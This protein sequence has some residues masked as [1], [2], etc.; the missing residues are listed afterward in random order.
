MREKESTRERRRMV[1]ERVRENERR[2]VWVLKRKGDI[3]Q[4]LEEKGG[5]VTFMHWDT[6]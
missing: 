2:F 5:H 1:G 4:W 3:C 6:C